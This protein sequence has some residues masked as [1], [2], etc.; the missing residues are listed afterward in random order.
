MTV[1]SLYVL[2]WKLFGNLVYSF[3][4]LQF[5]SEVSKALF[6]KKIRQ[7]G[8]LYLLSVSDINCFYKMY[9][10]KNKQWDILVN[11]VSKIG[12]ICRATKSLSKE[13]EKKL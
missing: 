6:K 3:S 13:N 7:A 4:V 10:Y 2:S 9:T 8:F 11:E 1:T 5:N 12:H